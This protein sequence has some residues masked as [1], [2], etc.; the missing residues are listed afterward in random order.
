MQ[1]LTSPS[2]R[3]IYSL[4]DVLDRLDACKPASATAWH[5][6]VDDLQVSLKR[7][8]GA[9][10]SCSSSSSS[11]LHVILAGSLCMMQQIYPGAG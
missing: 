2:G 8:L 5:K 11:S 9:F 4:F 3:P 6:L 10:C 7:A 1:R